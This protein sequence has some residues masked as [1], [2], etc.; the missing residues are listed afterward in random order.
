[1]R[2]G[3][4]LGSNLGD[5]PGH[6]Q[7]GRRRLLAL[8]DDSGPFLC[9]KIYESTPV[10]CPDGSPQFLN[11]AIELSTDLPPLD[12]LATLQ[13]IESESGRHCRTTFCLETSKGHLS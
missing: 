6:L 12:L 9:S 5:R 3:I 1:M 8:H 7:E 11:A 4:A 13:A 2:A 10:E